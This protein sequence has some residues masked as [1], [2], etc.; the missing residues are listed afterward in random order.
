MVHF[1]QVFGL[2][3]ESVLSCPE[4]VAADPRP[5][6]DVLIRYD[7]VPASLDDAVESGPRWQAKPGLYLLNA[8][9]A[10]RYLVQNGREIVVHPEHGISED[11]LRAILLSTGLSILLHQR[12]LL[13]L[14]GSG[15]QTE[16]GAVAFAGNS[17]AG[18]STLVAAF[19]QRGFKMISD[20][21]LALIV[22][23]DAVITALPGFP[24]VSLW[25]DSAK[26]LGR[27]TRGLQRVNPDID[28]YISPEPG[29][30]HSAPSRLHAIYV[31]KADESAEPRLVP[32]NH[33][34]RFNALLNHTWQR[35]I[36]TGLGVRERHFQMAAQIAD[37]T[38]GASVS[39]SGQLF[40]VGKVA[41][42][43]ESDMRQDHTPA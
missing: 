36:L 25:A 38:Y 42:L 30:F 17:G 28:K 5:R 41:D 27:S 13:P 32:L 21:M 4:L 12:G 31:L 20:D 22:G 15:I 10:A 11:D 24:H 6:P 1:Y 14:H 23:D 8:G 29:A 18:K 19:L 26:A 37:R 43:I 35:S 9:R 7:N 40:D 16:S 2:L 34:G 3:V 33:A 39:R